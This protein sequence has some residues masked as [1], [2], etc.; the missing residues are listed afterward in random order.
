MEVTTAPGHANVYGVD[1]WIDF[2]M[3][4][5]GDAHA[6]AREV[7]AEGGLLSINHDKPPIP[8]DFEVPDADC[9]EV[10][11][12]AWPMRNWI[13]LARWQDRLASGRRLAA[14]G[15]SDFH[16]PDRLLPEGPL[17]LGRPTTVLHL[18]ALSEAA[19]LAAM[20]AGSGYVTES[21]TGPHLALFAGDTPMG[22]A[23]PAGPV[24]AEAQVRGAAGDSLAWIDASGPVRVVPIPAD[25]W[26]DRFLG[27]PRRFLRAEI[28]A[29][30][31]RDAILGAFRAVVG[32]RPLP[33]GLGEAELAA[34][35]VRRAI[36]NPLYVEA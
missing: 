4:S 20:K 32:D 11:Q 2:R 14:I 15:G 12:S 17:T 25:D 22:G 19:I 29:H 27:V 35:P 33:E 7:H 28:V 26:S 3:T 6:L 1:R 23:I 18:P 30:A 10:W 8:W 34:H 5:P 31:S 36:C 24:A 21:P 13:S 16:Q 9:M